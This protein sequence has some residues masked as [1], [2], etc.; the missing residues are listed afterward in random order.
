MTAPTGKLG[1]RYGLG[2]DGALVTTYLDGSEQLDGSADVKL[3]AWN[4]QRE[5]LRRLKFET[6]GTLVE[7]LSSFN[8]R[9]GLVRQ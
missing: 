5:G 9:V 6:R 2:P 8:R 4:V 3:V 7:T 1:E